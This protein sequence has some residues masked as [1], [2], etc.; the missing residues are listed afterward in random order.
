MAIDGEIEREIER[1]LF[2]Q[3]QTGKCTYVKMERERYKEINT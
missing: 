1:E 3:P 2:R